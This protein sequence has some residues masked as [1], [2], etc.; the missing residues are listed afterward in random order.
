MFV[1]RM[2]D[3][4]E[5]SPSDSSPVAEATDAS[6]DTAGLKKGTFSPTQTQRSMQPSVLPSEVD[7]PPLN[8]GLPSS[9][10]FASSFAAVSDTADA[11]SREQRQD[12]GPENNS[13]LNMYSVNATTPENN[14]RL[15]CANASSPVTAT[16]VDLPVPTNTESTN[17][18]SN[19]VE[20]PK[21]ENPWV[22][23]R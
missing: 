20:N 13:L 6:T 2:V 5:K 7:D 4:Q 1:R 11:I 10:P 12:G 15:H 3:V 18:N 8:H 22:K 14:G 17:S 16:V 21:D 19:S 23:H 9:Y